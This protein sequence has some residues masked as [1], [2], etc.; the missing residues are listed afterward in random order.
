M[1]R[2]IGP[3]YIAQYRQSGG[4]H[5]WIPSGLSAFSFGYRYTTLKS[6]VA[7][8]QAG[9]SANGLRYRILKGKKVV[10]QIKP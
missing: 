2:I 9:S 8:L 7:A 5:L 3:K 6:F 4:E 10:R 1:S